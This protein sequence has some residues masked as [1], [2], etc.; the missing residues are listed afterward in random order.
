MPGLVQVALIFAADAVR[1]LPKLEWERRATR[2]VTPKRRTSSAASS[3]I[4]AICS[5][6]VEVAQRFR[7]NFPAVYS[8]FMRIRGQF[9]DLDIS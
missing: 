7:E 1:A 4:S 9:C 3:A 8:E 2:G 6:G 5:A